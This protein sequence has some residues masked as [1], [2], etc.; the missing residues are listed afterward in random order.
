M[1][2]VT[3]L[4]I[5]TN[6]I[7]MSKGF[8]SELERQLRA[9]AQALAGIDLADGGYALAPPDGGFTAQFRTVAHIVIG[10]IEAYVVDPAARGHAVALAWRSRSR[11]DQRIEPT[12]D[13]ADVEFFWLALPIAELSADTRLDVSAVAKA[14]TAG[15]PIDW[16]VHDWSSMRLRWV[17]RRGFSPDEQTALAT[18][19]ADALRDWNTSASAKIHYVSEPRLSPDR[20]VVEFYVDLGA[21]GPDAV[22][23]LINA[24]AASAAAPAIA[25]AA[26]GRRG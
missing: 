16:D 17:A 24:V 21:A 10:V 9:Q 15:F 12:D 11:P 20:S 2:S 14:V 23:S 8:A 13:A 4:T 6:E 18:A 25:R 3:W 1:P 26:L 19:L 5:L 22:V 7:A